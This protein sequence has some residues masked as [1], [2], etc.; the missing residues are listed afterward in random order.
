MWRTLFGRTRNATA[1][2]LVALGCASGNAVASWI[3]IVDPDLTDGATNPGYPANQNPVTIGLYLQD[4]LNLAVTPTLLGQ[5]DSYGGGPLSGLGEPEPLKPF[6]LAFHFGNGNN[7]WEHDGNFDVFYIC[8]E[9]CNSFTLPS[10]KG[11][12]NYRLYLDPPPATNV[13]E[14]GMLALF[15]AGLAGLAFSRRKR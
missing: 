8:S 9:G 1:I 7:Y 15:G 12:S 14:P 6:L 5:N 3:F 11:I 10:T 2:L 13:P 4:L